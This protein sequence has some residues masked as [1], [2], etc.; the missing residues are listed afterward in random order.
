[1]VAIETD[2]IQ[3]QNA[4]LKQWPN[5]SDA[6]LSYFDRIAHGPNYTPQQAIRRLSA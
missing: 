5:G 6:Y 4:F 3:A 2:F 1:M